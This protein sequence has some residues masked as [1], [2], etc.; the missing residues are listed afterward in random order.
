MFAVQSLD[1]DILF[2]D[3][4]SRDRQVSMI[5]FQLHSAPVFVCT[6]GYRGDDHRMGLPELKQQPTRT[7]S[8]EALYG[9]FPGSS[10]LT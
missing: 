1:T 10:H 6:V 8:T 7:N 9:W 2:L 5:C 3:T 4:Q